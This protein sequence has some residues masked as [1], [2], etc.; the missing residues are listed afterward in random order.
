M[1]HYVLTTLLLLLLSATPAAA[2]ESGC[3]PGL[4]YGGQC[5]GTVID[6]CENGEHFSVD[7]ALSGKACVWTDNAGYDC[8]DPSQASTQ[9][10]TGPSTTGG[11]T[12]GGGTMGGGTGL[13]KPDFGGGAPSNSGGCTLTSA[14]APPSPPLLVGM[15]L[16]LLLL[17]RRRS[18]SLT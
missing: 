6:W 13:V 8:L 3:P 12:M 7:C 9:P 18:P 15:G 16:G 4:D 11:G 10:G 2:Q 14:H 1:N 5:N 17:L